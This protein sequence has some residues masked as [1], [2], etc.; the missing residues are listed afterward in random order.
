MENAGLDRT[1]PPALRELNQVFV[2]VAEG[3]CSREKFARAWARVRF[4]GKAH[5]GDRRAVRLGMA[6]LGAIAHA[7]QTLVSH[8]LPNNFPPETYFLANKCPLMLNFGKG[9][10]RPSG[11]NCY[12]NN[13]Q[14]I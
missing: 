13:H 6:G 3:A 8:P 9:F 14:L 2:A 1:H 4:V 5:A 7:C 12:Q 10:M 11:K